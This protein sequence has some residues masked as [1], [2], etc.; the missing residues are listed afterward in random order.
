MICP[1]AT[2]Y[3]ASKHAKA[4]AGGILDF[5]SSVAPTSN[6]TQHES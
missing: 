5:P 6:F 3:P 4:T 2:T 1:G